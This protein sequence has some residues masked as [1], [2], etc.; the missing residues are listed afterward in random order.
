MSG[1]DSQCVLGHTYGTTRLAN[2]KKLEGRER[3]RYLWEVDNF[4]IFRNL[5]SALELFPLRCIVRSQFI[6]DISYVSIQVV[7]RR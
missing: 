5:G 2:E 4:D 7:Y 1:S 6:L 3:N